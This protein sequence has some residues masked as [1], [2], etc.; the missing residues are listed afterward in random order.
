MVATEGFAPPRTRPL[1]LSQLRL[2]FRHAAFIKDAHLGQSLAAYQLL[3]CRFVALALSVAMSEIVGRGSGTRT[4]TIRGL[5]PL[6]AANWAMPPFLKLKRYLTNLL[7]GI[8]PFSAI[9]EFLT[10][11]RGLV[12]ESQNRLASWRGHRGTIP[13]PS[14]RQ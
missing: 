13:K 10:R 12:T 11:V 14:H 5:N 7:A 2:L 1:G 3:R 9:I 4:H 6:P 8:E